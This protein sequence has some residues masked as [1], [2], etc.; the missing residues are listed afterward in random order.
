VRTGAATTSGSPRWR[1]P[2][3]RSGAHQLL[4]VPRGH[5]IDSPI[6]P[7]QPDSERYLAI[8]C[9][10]ARIPGLCPRSGHRD[11]HPCRKLARGNAPGRY[12]WSERPGRGAGSE[13]GGRGAAPSHLG[14]TCRCLGRGE[15]HLHPCPTRR[16]TS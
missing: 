6:T 4:A 7:P 10:A 12:R 2:F 14:S 5:S 15:P 3:S 1:P 13:R 9:A 16:C 11:R 8:G